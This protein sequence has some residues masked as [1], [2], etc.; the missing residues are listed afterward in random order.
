MEY[1]NRGRIKIAFRLSIRLFTH[2]GF[3]DMHGIC[4]H[5]RSDRAAADGETYMRSR[6]RRSIVD[7]WKLQIGSSLNFFT[8]DWGKLGNRSIHECTIHALAP[9]MPSDSSLKTCRVKGKEKG[10]RGREVPC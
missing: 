5:I 1:E 7:E 9:V 6:R 3:G 8:A 4:M 2:S 10:K